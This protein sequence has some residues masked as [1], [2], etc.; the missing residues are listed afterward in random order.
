MPLPFALDHI[1]LWALADGDG[2]T[3]HQEFLFGTSPVAGNASLL[4]TTANSGN[5]DLRWQQ[6]ETGATYLLKQSTTLAA[7]SWTTVT[8]QNPAMDGNQAG[9]PAD[10]DY[11][12]V[13][14]PAAGG[15]MF[16]RIQGVEN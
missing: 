9:A 10:Y 15:S 5:L 2:F 4:S 1:H 11:Y 3:N 8:S 6:R 16:Y 14:L 7:G 12:T 13:S